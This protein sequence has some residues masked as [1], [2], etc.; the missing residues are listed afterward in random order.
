MAGLSHAH[1]KF[2][3][4]VW[5]AAIYMLMCEPASG[6]PAATGHQQTGVSSHARSPPLSS[7]GGPDVSVAH[8]RLPFAPRPSADAEGT[9][10]VSP[11]AASGDQGDQPGRSAMHGV[12][13]R[14]RAAR[15]Q[16]CLVPR[17]SL[18]C[19]FNLRAISLVRYEY[20]GYTYLLHFQTHTTPFLNVNRIRV[21]QHSVVI[22]M[23]IYV[24]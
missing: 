19:V 3:H 16:P 23:T 17:C 8:F 5:S 18:K 9:E 1:C 4:P 24:N 10:D 13:G 12:T 15:P 7:A 21:K 11:V 14:R 6:A 20:I 2:R 22:S